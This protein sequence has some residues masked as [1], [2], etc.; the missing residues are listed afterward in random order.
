M[1]VLI[2]GAT[3]FIGAHV[4]RMLITRGH[5]VR[6]LVRKTSS[7]TNLQDLALERAEG[8]V[9]DA[10]SVR[11]ALQ[12]CDAVVHTAGVAHFMPGE[13]TRMYAV[14]D[15]GVR[16]VL[17]EALKAGVK[18]AVMT[19]STACLGGS[20]T[21]RVAD[22]STPSNAEA[23]GI[24]YFISKYRGEQAA[25]ALAKEGL[26][27]CTLLPVV[28]LGPGDIYASSATTFKGIA[29]RQI[30][31]Y[32][33]G[34]ASFCDVRDV[35]S[36]H[37][38]ALEKGRPGERY[39]LGGHNLEIADMMART[40]RMAGVSVPRQV[41]F[42]I[43]YAAAGATELACKLTGSKPPFSRQMLK[44]SRLYTWVKSDKAIAELEYQL[45]PFDE[46]LKDTLQFFLKVGRLKPT[47]HELKALLD[48]AG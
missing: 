20:P 17:G 7:L 13:E 48:A 33:P 44:S 35:A 1:H 40:A 21:P 23:S 34:G 27:V 4:A 26:H 15:G 28:C 19:A 42:P 12:G 16:I 46:S 32:V 45:R 18:R 38:A 37:V 6:A 36:A 3:G 31:V 29:A 41:P 22:E 25:L 8:D 39:I 9:C 30:P 10:A 24:D 47:T 14:N 43:A 11:A 5:T 2:T